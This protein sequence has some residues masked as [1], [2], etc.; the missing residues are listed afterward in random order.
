MIKDHSLYANLIVNLQNLSNTDHLYGPDY[1]RYNYGLADR[2]CH[3]HT[4]L[5]YFIY[6]PRGVAEGDYIIIIT[7]L[8]VIICN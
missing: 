6:N 4:K 3:N 8:S 2:S 5:S 7:K 1:C